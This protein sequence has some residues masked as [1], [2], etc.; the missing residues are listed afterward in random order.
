MN[1]TTESANFMTRAIA[2]IIDAVVLAVAG[3][4]L[5]FIP[6]LGLIVG[7]VLPWIYYV[8]CWS[9]ENPIGLKG[10]TLGKKLMKI[11]VV[12]DNGADLTIQQALIRCLGY[13]VTGL[14]LGL[15]SLLALRPDHKAL[16][17]LIA[18][19]KVIKV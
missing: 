13:L 14:T 12:M 10:Q 17:D 3:R 19:T 16:H 18:G 7:L 6:I 2:I 11:K 15:G 1:E 8:Y 9:Y 4:I 5:G